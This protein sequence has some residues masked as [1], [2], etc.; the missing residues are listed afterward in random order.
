MWL[1]A[2]C[3]PLRLLP[4]PCPADDSSEGS[5]GEEQGQEDA[6]LNPWLQDEFGADIQQQVGS[7]PHTGQCALSSCP[8]V[9][10]T[11]L[12]ASLLR[13]RSSLL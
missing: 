10:A 1:I 3:P 12:I 11:Q 7:A 8:Y 6:W 13:H 5:D 9:R 2:A 4:A